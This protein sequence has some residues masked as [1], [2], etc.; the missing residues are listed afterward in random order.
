M[1]TRGSRCTHL[2]TSAHICSCCVFLSGPWPENPKDLLQCGVSWCLGLPQVRCTAG[3]AVGASLLRGGSLFWRQLWGFCTA[4]FLFLFFYFPRGFLFL[5]LAL[6][7]LSASDKSPALFILSC[8]GWSRPL[9]AV[10]AAGAA[11]PVL[12][13]RGLLSGSLGGTDLGLSIRVCSAPGAGPAALSCCFWAGL[14]F[15]GGLVWFC[16]GWFFPRRISGLF[17][18]F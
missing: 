16:G 14:A 4:S 15:G 1:E 17:D 8:A 7:A 3:A 10:P 2:H 11:L 13:G 6:L 5:L 18:H 9:C 12:P